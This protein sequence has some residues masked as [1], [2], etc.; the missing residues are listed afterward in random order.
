MLILKFHFVSSS[1]ASLSVLLLLLHGL[2]IF[3]D[4]NVGL[5]L[6]LVG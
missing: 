5:L 6:L 3:R 2:Y 4:S 1:Y